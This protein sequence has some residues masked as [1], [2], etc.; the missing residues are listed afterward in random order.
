[1]KMSHIKSL[2]KYTASFVDELVSSGL[3]DVVIS[4]GSR[5]TPLAL[6]V[7][8][9]D[10]LTDWIVIDER[11]AAFFA[12]GIAKAT[13]RPVALIC[14]SGTAAANYYPA[15][16]EAYHSRVPLVVL[17][18]DRPHEL[19]DVGAPQAIDQIHMFGNYV[20]YFH[21]MALPEASKEMLVYAR[22]QAARA[23][24]EADLGNK[25]PVHLNFPFREPLVPD[26]TIEKVF[27]AEKGHPSFNPVFEGKRNLPF[28]AQLQLKQMLTHKK[29]GVIVCGP[30][31]NILDQERII[32]F[33]KAWNLP[34]LADPLSQ[35][36]AGEFSKDVIIDSYDAILREK[37][38][39]DYLKPDFIIRFGAM[40]VS[41]MYLFYAQEND[42]V[43]HFVIEAEGGY[44]EPA[45]VNTSFLHT[46]PGL[47][48]ESLMPGFEVKVDGWIRLWRRMN[49][50]VYKHIFM[51]ESSEITEGE[52]VRGIR[53]VIPPHTTLFIA[54]SMAIRDV[55]TFFTN[56]NK[57]VRMLANRGVNGIDGVTSTALGVAASEGRVTLIIGDLSF[58]HD[59]NGLL[60]AKHFELDVTL[61]LVNNDG[62]G[63]FS[64]LPQ[65]KDP[66]HFD[67]LFGTPV[68]IDFKPA[69]EMYG[70]VYELVGT[71][72]ELKES[73]QASYKR[74][75]LSVIEVRTDRE[76][77]AVWHRK[78][79]EQINK[80]LL[81]IVEEGGQ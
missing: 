7:R 5:S 3:T 52:A 38:V 12:L 18:T 77:N 71:E 49:A 40:P 74:S 6:T 45:N 67:A 51:P 43:P 27:E 54:N 22:R 19:R 14:T 65:A 15:I 39:R 68:G 58:Y 80:D 75:G 25:G 69:V 20:K 60:M 28:D 4:P 24:F 76:E 79:W 23:F 46:D 50:K 36:R 78:I 66:K 59:L 57:P 21:E 55:D 1:M 62:G 13:D 17:T 26:F 31:Q 10:G 56:I 16:I 2:T 64:F 70:G 41:K 30:D 44:R 72:R 35:L 32:R 53:E 48:C 33:A 11:S 47:F 81:A 37:R 8:E 34:I 61:V 29:R 42:D 63:I 73:L 9:H